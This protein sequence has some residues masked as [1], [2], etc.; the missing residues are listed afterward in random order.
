MDLD[1]TFKEIDAH[2]D[3][4][5]KEIRA[6][7]DARAAEIQA[8]FEKDCADIEAKYRT[9]D[10]VVKTLITL[11]MLGLGFTLYSAIQSDRTLAN[12]ND[13][14]VNAGGVFAKVYDGY[15]CF[16]KDSLKTVEVK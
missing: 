15:E 6:H 12:K 10:R 9:G 5:R 3:A 13:A 11:G 14:C 16:S 7:H 1:K 8:K 2:L 4:H